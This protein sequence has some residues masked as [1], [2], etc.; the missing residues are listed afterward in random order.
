MNTF[1]P[2]VPCTDLVKG[3]MIASSLL[4]IMCIVLFSCYTSLITVLSVLR[5]EPC[6][7]ESRQLNMESSMSHFK[8]TFGLA[9]CKVG[10]CI[11]SLFAALKSKQLELS[12][13]GDLFDECKV[14]LR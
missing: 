10:S 8:H 13:I 12:T 2:V 6:A 9:S 14:Q 5:K 4:T 3:F 1:P 11:F 7:A